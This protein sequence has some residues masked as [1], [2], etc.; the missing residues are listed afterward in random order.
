MYN[1]SYSIVVMIAEGGFIFNAVLMSTAH[2][3]NGCLPLYGE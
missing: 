1:R 3:Q 2:L